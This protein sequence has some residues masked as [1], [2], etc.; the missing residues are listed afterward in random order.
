MISKDSYSISI[1][2][3]MFNFTYTINF[4]ICVMVM[5]VIYI[6]LWK[7]EKK[8]NNY[9]LWSELLHL[10]NSRIVFFFIVIQRFSCSASTFQLK[11]IAW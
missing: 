6:I 8:N 5:W 1:V 7:F 9:V 11:K 10:S 2:T 3:V 4:H